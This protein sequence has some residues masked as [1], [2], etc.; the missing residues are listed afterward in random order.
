MI[1]RMLL[2]I[3]G[4]IVVPTALSGLEPILIILRRNYDSHH[5][6]D[7]YGWILKEQAG[8]TTVSDSQHPTDARGWNV[9]LKEEAGNATIYNGD[10]PTHANVL[11]LTE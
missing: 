8:N 1:D 11:I 9:I 2:N 5:T 10:H 6:T 3:A 7:A 4:H